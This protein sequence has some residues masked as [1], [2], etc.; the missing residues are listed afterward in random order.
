M[1]TYSLHQ[2]ILQKNGIV[3]IPRENKHRHLEKITG[4]CHW[5]FQTI[6]TMPFLETIQELN[7]F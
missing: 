6:L 3:R 1:L 7:Q 2:I 5:R 4:P